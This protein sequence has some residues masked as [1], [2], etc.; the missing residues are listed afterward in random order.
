MGEDEGEGEK[1]NPLT[2]TL[3]RCWERENKVK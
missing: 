3:S 2:L 1:E